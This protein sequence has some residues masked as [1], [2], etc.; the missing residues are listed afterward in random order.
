MA[1]KINRDKC[2]RCTGCVGICPV[3]ALTFDESRG[4]VIDEEKC[5]HCGLC[6]KFCPVGAIKVD[7]E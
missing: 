4:I 1:W 7:K 6:E 3:G 5:I 2:M